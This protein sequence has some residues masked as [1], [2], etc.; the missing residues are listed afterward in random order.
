MTGCG[1]EI[2]VPIKGE[3]LGASQPPEEQLDIAIGGDALDGIETG[4]RRTRN[5]E[6]RVWTKGQ[7]VGSDGGLLGPASLSR[8]ATLATVSRP[9]MPAR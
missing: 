6:V 4:C 7:M 8:P 9:S 2:A 1:I 5:V 3:A